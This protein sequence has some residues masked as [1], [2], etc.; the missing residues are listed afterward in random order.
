MCTASIHHG[1]GPGADAPDDTTGETTAAGSTRRDLV[2]AAAGATRRDLVAAAAGVAVAAPLAAPG[3]ASAASP[4]HAEPAEA[5]L[6]RSTMELEPGRGALVV[7][8]P[9]IDFLSETGV[10]SCVVGESATGHGVVGT[11]ARLFRAV[12]EAGIPVPMSPRCCCPP[13]HGRVL[14]SARIPEGD[15]SLAAPI[16]FRMMANA[17]RTTDDAV[18]RPSAVRG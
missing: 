3:A 6:P 11:L 8:D 7:V 12:R 2:A 10:A 5:A 13:D 16:D 18:A 9:R 17:V 15:G 14:D 4:A 1:H